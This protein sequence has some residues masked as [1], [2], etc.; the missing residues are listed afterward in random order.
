MADLSSKGVVNLVSDEVKQIYSLLEA[1]FTPLELCQRLAPLLE[2]LENTTKQM[3]GQCSPCPPFCC[4]CGANCADVV[5]LQVRTY[6]LASW[7]CSLYTNRVLCH[8][9]A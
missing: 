9:T 3:S 4:P 1:D 7:S 8:D 6:C 5:C 2:S